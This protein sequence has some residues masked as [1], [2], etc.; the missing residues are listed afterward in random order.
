MTHTGKNALRPVQSLFTAIQELRLRFE[1]AKGP[2]N[3]LVIDSL[4]KP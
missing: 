3:V 2:V 1:S 4:Q